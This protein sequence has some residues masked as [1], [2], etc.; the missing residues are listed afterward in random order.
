M[1]KFLTACLLMLLTIT[2]ASAASAPLPAPPEIPAKGYVLLDAFSGRILVG[3]NDTE[4]LEPAS[5]T[6]LMT[7]YVVFHALHDHKLSLDQTATISEHAWRAGGAVSDGSTSYMPLGSQVKVEDLIQGMIVQSGN[8]ATIA[9][10]EKIAGTEATFTVLMNQYSERL[11]LKGSHWNNTAGL[12]DPQHYTTARDVAILGA[13]LV[14]EFPE[15]Y[16]WFSQ[17]SFT[18]NK[19]TQHNRNGL[20]DRDPTVDGIK[21]GHTEAAGYCLA[22]SALRDGMRLVAVVMGS[23]STKARE[24]ASETL[25]GYGF[26]FFETK[27]LYTAGQHVGVA[28]VW[29][30]SEPVQVALHG[31][32]FATGQRGEL[33]NA[34]GKLQLNPR[35]IAPLAANVEIGRLHVTLGDTLLADLPVY[36]ATAVEA[37]NIF[38]RAIDTV[39]LWFN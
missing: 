13:G 11:G 32:V 34:K 30:T 22:S 10:A 17:R 4:R 33:A 16:K 28:T 8:D 29:K 2:A 15:Y 36:P 37:G 26:N 6:K 19:I 14:R 21:T 24:D 23:A 25:L 1:L 38:R 7:S 3:H 9:L 39:R 5:L 27:R 31:E 35:L 18:F 12:P 20:L